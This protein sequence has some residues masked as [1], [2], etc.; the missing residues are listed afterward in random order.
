MNVVLRDLE[1][2]ASAVD[3][4]AELAV[5]GGMEGVTGNSIHFVCVLAVV[6]VSG[7]PKMGTLV[8][9]EFNHMKRFDDI[10]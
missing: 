10:E 1:D 2:H 6:V 5:L 4:G 7:Y 8:A 9:V 3:G